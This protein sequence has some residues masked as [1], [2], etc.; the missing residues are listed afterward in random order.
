MFSA[1]FCAWHPPLL[2]ALVRVKVFCNLM[3]E[4]FWVAQQIWGKAA[5]S[6]TAKKLF[7]FSFFANL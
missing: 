4:V 6:K 5:G 7:P 1:L 3:L 2:R